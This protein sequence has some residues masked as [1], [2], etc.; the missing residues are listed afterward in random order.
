MEMHWIIPGWGRGFKL[1]TINCINYSFIAVRKY[2]IKVTQVRKGLF[3]F[4][5]QGGVHQGGEGVASGTWGN[6]VSCCTVQNQKAESSRY[7]SSSCLLLCM[8]PGTPAHGIVSPAFRVGLPAS[9]NPTYIIPPRWGQRIVSEVF[10]DPVKLT[11]T[12]SP[13]SHPGTLWASFGCLW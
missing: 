5:V 12:T 4:T 7:P 3:R 1:T 6:C 9:I 10:L 2:L 11:I 8:Q 13:H